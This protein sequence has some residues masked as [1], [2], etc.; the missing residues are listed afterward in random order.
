M[1][2]IE[3]LNNL[4]LPCLPDDFL[5]HMFKPECWILWDFCHNC[6]AQSIFTIKNYKRTK[7][8]YLFSS[9]IGWDTFWFLFTYLHSPL[10]VCLFPCSWGKICA[11]TASWTFSSISISFLVKQFIPCQTKDISNVW[12]FRFA[13]LDI[14]LCVFF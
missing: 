9:Y 3:H 12:V 8:K 1:F 11:G 5:F 14:Q 6:W 7:S 2:N 4:S 13:L 10:I